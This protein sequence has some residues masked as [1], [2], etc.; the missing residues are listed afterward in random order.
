MRENN[1]IKNVKSELKINNNVSEVTPSALIHVI[2]KY[3]KCKTAIIIDGDY[4]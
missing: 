2:N 1:N 4:N 3:I